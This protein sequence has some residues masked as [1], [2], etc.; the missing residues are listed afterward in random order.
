LT[1]LLVSI[2]IY[3]TLAYRVARRT[4]EIGIRMALGARVGAVLRMVLEDVLVA[5][6]LGLAAGGVGAAVLGRLVGS[7]LYGL[8]P[9]D[10]TTIGLA[11]AVLS[12]A[13]IGAAYIPARRATR[14]DPAAA[15]RFE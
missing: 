8:R 15:V 10:L 9:N 3:G 11:A 13:T 2:G 6:V 1:L 14:V 12:A 7:M 5:L 4:N